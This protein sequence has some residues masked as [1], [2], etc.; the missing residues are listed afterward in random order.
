[1]PRHA[2]LAV[3]L[4][5]LAS[6]ATR[7]TPAH[8]KDTWTTP[9]PGVRHL[10][11]TTTTP[12]R[13]HLLEVDLCHPGVRLQA[14]KTGERGRTTS[15]YGA[16][17]SAQAALNGDFHNADNNFKPSGLAIGGGAVW[18]DSA[19]N[20]FEGFV[21]FGRGRI[22]LFTPKPVDL[23]E[24]WMQ[25]AIAGRPHVVNN[26]VVLP[27][28]PDTAACFERNPRTAAGLSRDGRTLYLV[29]VD[30]RTQISE[31]VTCSELGALMAGLGA[32][33]A[34][35]WDGGGSTTLW[36]TGEGVVNDPSEGFQRIV[37][38][39][40]G[41]F[42]NGIGDPGSCDR[43]WEESAVAGDAYDASTTTDLDGDGRA[44]ICARA[45]AGI[46][47]AL[48]T[49]TGFGP[50]L[51]GPELSD[52]SGWSDPTNYAT[53]RMGD[54]DGD[55]KADLCARAN[56]G[57]RCWFSF[58]DHFGDGFDGPAWSDANGWDDPAYH[59][60][61]RLADI[62]ADGRDDLCGRSA[63]DFRCHRSTGG[64]FTEPILLPDL[65]DAQGFAD[66]ARHG[67]IR[68]ADIDADGRADVCARTGDGLRCWPS[69]GIGFAAP[70]SGPEWS[71][72]NG[73][74]ALEHWSTIRL[75]DID[76]DGR[77][78]AC[79]RGP[80]GFVCH[81]SEGTSFGPAIP[82]PGWRDDNGWSDYANFSTIRMADLDADGDA[83]VCARA[84]AK[85]VCATFDGA[86]F[87]PT[88]DGPVLSDAA[89]WNV[90]PRYATLRLADV[91]GDR[92]A[93]LCV[94]G[95]AGVTCHLS[96]GAGFPAA[97]PGPTWSDAQGWTAPQ[98]YATVHAAG[99]RCGFELC[100]GRDDDCDEQVDE[101]C[102]PGT[103]GD[104]SS[105]SSDGDSDSAPLATTGEP[106][107]TTDLPTGIGPTDSV[108]TDSAPVDPGQ[109]DAAGCG[110]T[111]P[112][113][114][115]ASLLLLLAIRRRRGSRA[116]LGAARVTRRR[117]P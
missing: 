51:L 114:T 74:S 1:M 116:P 36:L 106:T 105:S 80:D 82:G 60:T 68:L 103:T 22:E 111:A 98:Y 104:G 24:A 92:R 10:F 59:G 64:G 53:I 25:G 7:A 8:A 115:P 9:F 113:A 87:S 101:G 77:A 31:G 65:G 45:A 49:D 78:D 52:D 17:V 79:A 108:P 110:C 88:F 38:N 20:G 112:A 75:A 29:I 21:A 71:D 43:T 94:R 66:P 91:D 13:I 47:C 107:P 15:S 23:A 54:L 62:D 90:H 63:A 44:D 109:D 40:L 81:L 4:A 73:W 69:T 67:T 30:G 93:D 26:G 48:A 85:I 14:T 19:D 102:E 99:P 28:D 58:G 6:L 89:G 5:S 117:F 35:N 55:G 39:H 12:N 3:L 56:T 16:L 86:A 84:D 50:A 33:N 11:R 46:R 72:A 18:P 2:A 76:A 97:I 32:Y 70:I 95:E 27:D 61:I 34:L 100:N 37:S 96:D 41:L 83:D 42:A 57:M